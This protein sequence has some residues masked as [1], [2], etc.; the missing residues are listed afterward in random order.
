VVSAVPSTTA[1]KG[2]GTNFVDESSLNA[3]M[4]RTDADGDEQLSFQDFFSSLLPY[5][6]WGD[7][8]TKPPQI[9]IDQKENKSR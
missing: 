4:R 6:V 2:N 7:F 5:F 8:K 1:G 3:I 9:E